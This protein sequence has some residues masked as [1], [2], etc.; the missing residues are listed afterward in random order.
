M[1]SRPRNFIRRG[2]GT[3]C[4]RA[5][6]PLGLETIKLSGIDLKRGNDV[7]SSEATTGATT[8]GGGGGGGTKKKQRCDR[9]KEEK[10][11]ERGWVG[12]VGGVAG[13]R[14]VVTSGAFN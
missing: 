6:T 14:R 3:R 9:G 4:T 11:A 8:I 5:Y 1:S 2:K 13:R 12:R 10:R 7:G